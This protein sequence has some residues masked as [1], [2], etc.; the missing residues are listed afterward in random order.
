MQAFEDE[1]FEWLVR[2]VDQTIRAVPYKNVQNEHQG[3]FL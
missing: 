1:L 2:L 3:L